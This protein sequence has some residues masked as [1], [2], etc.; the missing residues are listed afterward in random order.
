[1]TP[2]HANT[3]QQSITIHAGEHLETTMT[4][5]ESLAI[6]SG[7]SSVQG[8]SMDKAGALLI[9]L[10]DGASLLIKNFAEIATSAGHSFITLPS[11]QA[12][13]LAELI[14]TLAPSAQDDA[15][16]ANATPTQQVLGIEPAAGGDA[17]TQAHVVI[18]GKPHAHE[19]VV[20]KL[21]QGDDYQLG[22]NMAD[23]ASVKE[24]H[25]QLVVAFKDGGE[26][27]IPNYGAMKDAGIPDFVMKDGT[28]LSVADFG[29]TLAQ[30]SQLNTV[31]PA[32]GGNGGGAHGGGFGFGSV[33]TADALN[34]INPIGP[35]AP[36]ELHYSTFDRT[37]L[38]FA[39]DDTPVISS[40]DLLSV[41]ETNLSGGVQTV[42]GAVIADFF[43]D[44]PGTITAS[45][46]SSFTADGSVSGG[47]LTSD[48]HPV[49]V[50][51]TGDTYTGTANG[52]TIFTLQINN[53]GT[54]T[55]HLDGTLDHAD[56]SNPNDVIN[57]NFGVTAT[58]KDGDTATTTVTVK[59]LDDAP[60][61]H[62]D[63][64]SF[65]GEDLTT[66][67][68]VVTGLNGG[69]GAADVLSQDAPNHVT[70]VTFGTTTVNVPT[71]GTTTIA[72]D[73]GVLTIAADG[74]YSYTLNPG[75]HG[76]T[77]DQ[78][79]Y[80]LTDED[81]D[82]STAGLLIDSDGVPTLFNPNDPTLSPGTRTVDETD[83]HGAG[84]STS[85]SG[86]L[87]AD[88]YTD[89][90]GT[91]SAATSGAFTATGSTGGALTSDGHPVTVTLSGDTY[92]GT[93]NGATV[94]TLHIN[95][96]GSYSFELDGTLDHAD[97]SNPNDV[98]NLNFGVSATDSDGDT[99][100]ATLTINVLDDAPIAHSDHNSFNGEDLTT[101]GNVVTG[102][103]GG[104]G[105]ADVLSQDQGNH[106]TEVTFGATTV[107]V[108]AAGT[109]TIAGASGV[110]TIAAD[111]TYSYT[112]NPGVHGDTA[113]Q[114]TY[115]LTDGD[116]DKSV[117]GLL[118]DSD[119]VPT[120]YDP[121]DPKESP[122]TRIVDESDLHGAGTDT[123]V[124]GHLNANFYTDTPGTF[125]A[126]GAGTFS[127]TGSMT[128]GALTSHGQPVTV[129]LAGDTYTGTANGAT[130]FTLHINTDGSYTFDL[131]GTLDH[132][133]GSN[134]ND[135]INLN[136]GVKAT[137]S[138][139]DSAT[140]TLTI[141]VLDDAPIA[142]DDTNNFNSE[143]HTTAGNVVTGDHGGPGAAD[144]LSQDGGNH[145]TQITFGGTTVNVP[146]TGTTTIAG[147]SGV[148]TIAADGSYSYT[149]NAGVH[150]DTADQF[151]YSLVDSDGDVSTAH[152]TIDS[153]GIPTIYNPNDPTLSPGTRTV[154][155]TDLHGASTSVAGHLNANFYTDTPG[156]YG[157]TG[158]GSFGAT[159]SMTGGALTS[160]GHPVS[161]TLTGNT[162]TG[163]ANGATVF[164]LTVNTDG[165]Y[166]FN[167]TGTLD[168]A[169]G[170]NPNDVI[171][172]NFG[173]SATDSDGDTASATLTIKVLDDA[174]IAHDDHNTFAFDVGH[175]DGN[176]ITGANGGAGAADTLSADAPNH[177]TQVSFGATTVNVPTTGTATIDGTYGE[178]K[179]SA[180]GSYTYTLFPGVT[181][182]SSTTTQHTFTGPGFPTD[183]HEGTAISAGDHANL[184]EI[185]SNMVI[186]ANTQVSGQVTFDGAGYTNSLGAFT[187][188]AD[189]SLQAVQ[190]VTPS[191]TGAG[192]GFNI[193]SS[194][195][196]QELGFFLVANGFTNNAG[197]AGL[198]FAHGQLKFVYDLGAGDQ[199]T[200]NVTDDGN[201]VSLVFT[202][203]GGHDHVISGP[204]YFTTDAGGSNSLNPDGVVHTISGVGSDSHTLTI[205]FEDLP[206]GG[207]SD[208]NDAIFN[209]QLT[210]TV[211]TPDLTD[212][213]V[214][215]LTDH[216]GDTSKANLDFNVPHD[217][218]PVITPPSTHSVD[219]T[220]LHSGNVVVTD[221]V[222]ANFFADGPGTIT[223]SGAG[224]FSAGGSV[225]G[226]TLTSGGVPV[227]V[228]QTGDTYTG[229][230]G[231][232]TVF[233]LT[234][235]TDGQYTFTLQGTL[236]HADGSNPDDVINLNF[237]VV[238]TDH[239]GDTAT[240]T[241]T[242]KVV[243]DAPL[244][245]DDNNAFNGEDHTT[246]GNVVSGLHGGAGAADT[247]SMDAPDHVT[248]VTFG[249]TTVNVP[250][251]GTTT[252]AGT[253]GVLTIAADGTYSYTLNAGVHGDTADQFTYK[254]TDSDGDSSTAHLNITSDG[255]PT[256]CNPNDPTLSPGNRTVDETDLHGATTSVSGHL[257]ANFYTDTPGTYGATG[258]GTFSAGGSLAG[259]ALTSDGHAVTVTLAGN[260]YTGTAN[261][262][263]VFTLTVNADGSY[264]FI[265][266]G[267]LDHADGS[268]PNDVINLNFGVKA[269][270]SDGDSATASLTIK[271]LDD[272]PIAHDDHNSFDW[273]VGHT[274]GDVITGAN[275]G[276]GAADTS[277][278]DAPNHVTQIAFGAT[279]VNVPT[280]GTA[281]ID[282]TYGELKI[283]ADGTYTYTL[284]P[285][286]GGGTTTTQHTFTGNHFP[287]DLQEGHAIS[288]A[289]QANLG[290]IHSNMVIGANTQVSG[291]V[292]FDGAGYTNSLGAFTIAA[293][294]TLQAVQMVTPSITGA[295]AAFNINSSAGA[296]ELG[297]FLVADGFTTNNGY[298]GLDFAHGQLNFVYDFG[299]GDQRA[300]K[301]TDDGSHVSLVFT[302]AGGHTHVLNGPIYYTT[303]AGGSNSL[304]A[305]GVVH[306]LS[307]V[308]SNSNTLTIAF[309]DLPNGGDHDYNDAIFNV[310][311]TDTV[312]TPPPADQF[313][314]TLT[315][316]DGDSSKANLY[317]NGTAPVICKPTLTACDV[318]VKEDHSVALNVNANLNAPHAGEQLTVTISGIAAGW[319]VDTTASGGT[320]DATTHTWS[321][322]LPAGVTSFSGGPTLTPP[323]NSDVDLT[324]LSVTATATDGAYTA[325]STGSENVYVD[326]VV[327]TPVLTVSSPVNFLWIIN[328]TNPSNINVATH[329]TD[330]DG[331]EQ[332]TKVVVDLNGGFT[333]PVG[334]YDTLADSGITLNHGTQ[335][336][337]GV[338]TIDV[339]AQ[340]GSSA[341]NNLQLIT[342][343][344]QDYYWALHNGPHSGTIEVQSYVSEVNT[345]GAENDLTDNSTIVTSYICYTFS[346]SPL[347]LDLDGNG[348]DIVGQNAGVKFDMTNDGVADNTSWV[349]ATDALLAID[350]NHNGTI[351]NQSELFGNTSTARDG[352]ANLAQYDGNHDNV[353]DAHDSAF[354][355][356]LVWQDT[357]QDG[358]SQ[359]DELH[360]LSSLGITAIS[361]TT[362]A[363]N[364][365]ISDATITNI[366]SVT[367]ADGHTTQLGD[368]WFNVQD[369]TDHT[370]A[371][372]NGTDSDDVVYGTFKNDVLAG[373]GGENVLTGGGGADTFVLAANG[374]A[375]IKDFHTGEGDKLDLMDILTAYD[376][377]TQS[378]HNF[379]TTVSD[380][381]NTLVQV[382]QT[383]TGLAFHTVAVLEGIT[384]DVATLVASGN[385]IA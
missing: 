82:S 28:K 3:T 279:T 19:N 360:S 303:D 265:L 294:G 169:D 185:H 47:T 335:T 292:T 349:G 278:A 383:G 301:V 384:T 162:Y 212:N 304:N 102:A 340:D 277:S 195:G 331:S 206:N 133:D 152:L 110:L 316:G 104:A 371:T 323:H 235:H 148:L 305:D 377:I 317:L 179:I 164:T 341:L 50:T 209:V 205:G 89:T 342:P 115:T 84:T 229:T 198:D 254:L 245:H 298:A 326:A 379:V 346:V 332:V 113:D 141:K 123:S 159:G 338:W 2:D 95:T 171:N 283:A 90:P 363:A 345:H 322:T 269:T 268:N 18:I 150:G 94:F 69:A 191:I 81:G 288:A 172:L 145:V 272:A 297:F 240:S 118:I 38:P 20:V 207:D 315:D 52:A 160:D 53:D 42:S 348:F 13:N 234:I 343:T 127:A 60:I 142:H 79:T 92:T 130:V 253:N 299:A 168:H 373:H 136:F 380:G 36:T 267:T 166:N 178:L 310:Q 70:E 197:Y 85:V 1:M 23:P 91:Y 375:D 252:I 157:V 211:K 344:T 146:D 65:N 143:D 132:A 24:Q 120:I 125:S 174:P 214:Y 32:A 324:G 362:T 261:G 318:W 262:A 184:G 5:G 26:I 357:N 382:D 107:N 147:A 275:G 328:Q 246:T 339:N 215:T 242:I 54:Y 46:A 151:T 358:V 247:L 337:H 356:I 34:S 177:V 112:L 365:N 300:A 320:Y 59:V 187:I 153:D 75:T 105:A 355:N 290:E 260:T 233:T 208:Y 71:A 35:I 255:V 186:G 17:P 366:S 217:D 138:D 293:D 97:G 257:N 149:L 139:G 329:V 291:Q 154:D 7:T 144:V 117:A 116:G 64:N 372:F 327:D 6:L 100:S 280:T 239:D 83:L 37:P 194:A 78:F 48:G 122:G 295:G 353:I 282:G 201:K 270:D 173:V 29:D 108:P 40:P 313:T 129:S 220:S 167:L 80:A 238:A 57:L 189:G 364:Q 258:A 193:G 21:H 225:A 45:G 376:P 227:V 43:H 33:F 241:L 308:G 200:A 381:A 98:I 121:N 296:Q 126:T 12:V 359:S 230:A 51:L 124:S 41:D 99:A 63:H 61:A 218:H 314:Y 183:L 44:G 74:T 4:A 236:D 378:L 368:A 248:Q 182:A 109:T 106:V 231:G 190:M 276:A 202:D 16:M 325:A 56:G 213:F 256:I 131:Q 243:D 176:V 263:T 352:F 266:D 181:S 73:H 31:E 361:L 101:T 8:M 87:N 273:T 103:N 274:A 228:T 14:Q 289:D 385:L 10:A 192:A 140:A 199:R 284:F 285:G 93:A 39:P 180:D 286:A 336:S 158:G 25:G 232:H 271:V 226:G 67:G 72:G 259:G 9:Q 307:G 119:G 22:F 114:F 196:A 66:T 30:A 330:T 15:V 221:T 311:L 319:A 134:P 86:H 96:D 224:S 264:K 370:G 49:T 244:A 216:D 302:D 77:T 170:S 27:I 165:S 62:G 135:V 367:Y 161:V 354:T 222:V 287:T 76:D 128:G 309:E 68:N 351:D 210:D 334:T 11:G 58:D 163:T 137:D 333:N 156:T 55:F 251:T 250:A 369:A 347:V 88:F 204:I 175:T 312:V 237:G 306:T 203:A 188:G 249:G 374:N 281:T 111:G 223:P 219:E 321:V 350:T 155:E